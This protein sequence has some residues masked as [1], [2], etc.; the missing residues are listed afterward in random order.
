MDPTGCQPDDIAALERVRYFDGMVLGVNDFEQ[1]QTYCRTKARRHNRL[2]HGWGIVTGLEV[3]PLGSSGGQVSV[4]PGYALDPCGNEII[5][6]APAIV[7]A[8]TEGEVALAVRFEECVVSEG[9]VRDSFVIQLLRDPGE[10]W[11]G[12]ANVTVDDQGAV[13]IDSSVRRRLSLD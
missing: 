1:E 13:A 12:L 9:R 3:T 8:P 6:G 7:D 11:V 4:A 10:P 2:L 5:I